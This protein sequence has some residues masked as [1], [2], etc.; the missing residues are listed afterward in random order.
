[1]NE[2]EE[3][4]SKLNS[5]KKIIGIKNWKDAKRSSKWD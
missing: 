2:Y 4:I 5:S 3:I 1:L